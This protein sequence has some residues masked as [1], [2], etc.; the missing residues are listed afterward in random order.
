MIRPLELPVTP[1]GE[2]CPDATVRVVGTAELA[3][4]PVVAP[5]SGVQCI[6]CELVVFH[7]WTKLV[8]DGALSLDEG[9]Q[10]LLREQEC[11]AFAVR[12]E[13]G[14]VLVHRRNLELDLEES[15]V[16]EPRK[17]P[18]E[19]LEILSRHNRRRD[20]GRGE[21]RFVER[22]LEPGTRVTVVGRASREP[23]PTGLGA[24]YR[25]APTQWTLGPGDRPLLVSND[26]RAT[27]A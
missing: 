5:C 21:V 7:V 19:W 12:S 20:F 27:R 23:A 24:G 1:V 13:S 26:P 14:A 18:P 15:E 2:L 6:A 9:K 10:R 16:F 4:D 22:R 17:V 25:R 8:F 11:A 3:G